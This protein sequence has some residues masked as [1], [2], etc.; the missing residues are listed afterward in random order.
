MQRILIFLVCL[1]GCGLCWMVWQAANGE[2]APQPVVVLLADEAGA[3]YIEL[4]A[5]DTS[6][7]EYIVQHIEPES[8]SLP[9]ALQELCDHEDFALKAVVIATG[10]SS[11]TGQLAI[12]LLQKNIPVVMAGPAP[13]QPVLNHPMA[14]YVGSEAAGGGEA[15]GKLFAE[16]FRDGALPDRNDDHLMQYIAFGT[17]ETPFSQEFLNAFLIECEHYG[18]YNDPVTLIEQE[19]VEDAAAEPAATLSGTP[20]LILFGGRTSGEDAFALA[21]QHGL[22]EGE[23]PTLLGG[24]AMTETDA[25]EVVE[26]GAMAAVYYDLVTVTRTVRTLVRNLAA[27]EAPLMGLDIPADGQQFHIPLLVYEG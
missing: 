5:I 25:K 6:D 24:F 22:L 3:E 8:N 19:P 16:E 9:T 11:R 4:G 14:W 27:E 10:S 21:A 2:Y 12:R 26:A 17:D 20:E 7:P 1:A 13:A 23:T 18:V 15:L